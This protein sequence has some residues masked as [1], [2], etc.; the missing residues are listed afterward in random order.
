M[1][2]L[3]GEEDFGG[4][5]LVG[6]FDAGEFFAR[7]WLVGDNNYEFRITNYECSHYS[8]VP[9]RMHLWP[10]MTVCW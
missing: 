4:G 9:V 10:L 1:R 3:A 6:A 5:K 8:L 7:G 2:G